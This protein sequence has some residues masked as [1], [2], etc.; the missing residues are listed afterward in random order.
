[1]SSDRNRCARLVTAAN[2]AFIAVLLLAAN[3]T[4]GNGAEGGA[5][6]ALWDTQSPFGEKLTLSGRSDWKPVPTDL[7]A[8]EVNPRKASSDPGYYGREYF[9]KGDAIVESRRHVAVFWSTQGKVVVYAKEGANPS[10]SA[11]PDAGLEGKLL[12]IGALPANAGP[13]TIQRAEILRNATDEVVLEI[14]FAV[15]GSPERTAVFGFDKSG[16]IE[17]KPASDMR[18]IC[19]RSAMD[20]GVVPSFIGDDLI[21]NPRDYPTQATLCIPAE[22]LL[23][24]LVQ[25]EQNALVMTWPL[26][27]QRMRLQ[28]AGSEEKRLIESLEFENDGQSMYLATLSAP[29]I[30][31][32][33]ALE[34]SYLEKDVAIDWK[35][36]F[37]AKWKTQLYEDGTRTTFAFRNSREEIWRGVPGS[38]TYPVWFDGEQAFYHLSKKVP[39]KGESLIYFVEGQG[40]PPGVWTPVDILKAT[41]GGPMAAPIL[42]VAGRKLRTHHRRGADGVRRACT[43]G[44]TE[45]IQAVFAAQQEDTRKEYI[46]GAVQD[47]IY[48][49]HRHVERINEYRRFADG[50]IKFL[51][52]QGNASAA[53]KPYLDNLEPIVRRIP[54]EYEVQKENMKSFEYADDLARRTVALAGKK[55][56]DNLSAY[57]KL[58]KEW[59]DMGGAQDYLLALCH[60]ITRKFYQE[61]GYGCVAS[62]KAVTVAQEIRARCRRCLRNPDGYEIWADY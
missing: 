10:G 24:G 62:P 8:L 23:L 61:A 58:L 55:D 31:H 20:Y 27:H 51:Q 47:M 43:C 54:E 30:W 7:L 50:M 41:L 52:A 16:V 53:L 34:P 22:N 4:P 21:F 44:C 19:L 28:L 17:I 56:P 6:V 1:M 14:A 35:H 49:V 29:G 48:F 33:Q 18:G 26:G 32:R 45:A 42:D 25:G 9:F 37:P 5:N 59:R 2:A 46:A 38:Y 3:A 57:A 13:T 15:K 36:P 12:E 60:T 39:P 11:S 40:T